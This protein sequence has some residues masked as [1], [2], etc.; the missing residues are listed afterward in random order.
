MSFSRKI[1]TLCYD[2]NFGGTIISRSNSI[3]DLGIVFDRKMTFELHINYVISRSMSM[4]GFVK[5]F[6]KEFTDP[7]VLKTIYWAFV[8]A[9]FWNMGHV[10]GLQILKC[11]GAELRVCSESF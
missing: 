9:L 2:Y 4:L 6:G 10:F 3:K 7:Y 5:R 11:I 8:Y 1:D